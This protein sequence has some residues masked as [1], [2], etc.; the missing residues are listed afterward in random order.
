VQ[1]HR[2]ASHERSPALRGDAAGEG[3]PEAQLL[4]GPPFGYD[5]VFTTVINKHY[6]QIT[7]AFPTWAAT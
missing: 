2:T 1:V 6:I 7:S 4:P 5:T 3:V